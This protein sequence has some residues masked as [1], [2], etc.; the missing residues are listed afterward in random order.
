MPLLYKIVADIHRVTFKNALEVK[1]TAKSFWANH[2]RSRKKIYFIGCLSVAITNLGDVL[3]PKTIEWIINNFVKHNTLYMTAFWVMTGAYTAQLIARYAWRI[4][5]ARETHLTEAQLKSLLWNRIRFLP[6]K[7][8]QQRLTVGELMNVGAGDLRTA[9]FLFG[10]T[11]VG[12]T[13]F[14]FLLTFS[15][16]AMFLIDLKLSLAALAVIPFVPIAINKLTKLEHKYHTEAQDKLSD[17]TDTSSQAVST[18]RLQR[19]SQTGSYWT[20]KLLESALRYRSARFR[21][22]KNGIAFIPSTGIAPL[23]SYSVLIFYGAHKVFSGELSIGSFVAMQ[24]LIFIV[25]GPL[26]ELGS[27]ISEWQRGFASLRRYLDVLNE[28]EEPLLRSGGVKITPISDV[29][30]VK[31]LS[32]SFDSSSKPLFEKLSFELKQGDRLGIVGPVGTGKST[33][34][35]IL[36]GFNKDYQG[37][38]T[39]FGTNL[40]D[41][42][43]YSLRKNLACVPQKTFLFADSL[44]NNVALELNLSDDQLWHYLEIACLADDVRK[45]PNGLDTTLGEWGINLSGGQKQR[46]T[47]ARALAA[48]TPVMLFDDCLSAVDTVTEDKILTNLDKHCKS[49]T[50]VWVAHRRSTLK[51]C[52]HIID[53]EPAT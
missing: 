14:I 37:E 44:R 19:L 16:T 40:K 30:S 20:L 10:F 5:L 3:I 45:F 39:L 22:L 21:S 17:L 6:E 35:R 38:V 28:N 42:E 18:I 8:L 36:G 48:Q 46:L 12:T 29:Y 26:I 41:A 47:I 1:Q 13:D 7:V 23:I 25:Q 50:I 49:Q 53:L 2:I 31:N 11:L 32:F 33:L 43:H 27:I 51:H 34:I 15:L 4:T 24:S 52:N 9:R